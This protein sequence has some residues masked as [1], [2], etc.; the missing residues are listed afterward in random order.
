MVSPR[1]NVWLV[2]L[3]ELCLKFLFLTFNL[4][5]NHEFS[6][7]QVCGVLSEVL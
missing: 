1:V 6:L 4:T 5:Y 2:Q 7:T 3:K